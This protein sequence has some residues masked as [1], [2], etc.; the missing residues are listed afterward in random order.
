[1]APIAS[2]GMGGG[3]LKSEPTYAAA[4]TS[5]STPSVTRPTPSRGRVVPA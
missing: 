5:V 2:A 3:G 4:S 1:M